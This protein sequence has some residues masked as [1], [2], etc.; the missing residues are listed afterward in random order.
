[1]KISPLHG[2]AYANQHEELKHHVV[3]VPML[4]IYDG[5]AN[6]QVEVNTDASAKVFG[7]V[8]L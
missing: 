5:S 2:L 3:S 4:E 6:T 1:M 8:L 7:T